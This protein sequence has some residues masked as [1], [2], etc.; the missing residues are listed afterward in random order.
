MT[1]FAVEYVYGTGTDAARDE[2]RP[3]HRAFLASLTDAEGVSLVASGP[4]ADGSGALLIL[5]A[6]DEARLASALQQ[7]PFNA[8]GLVSAL[9]TTAWIPATGELAHH[10]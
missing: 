8:Q 10:A 9:R 7:D 5:R 3:E 1:I 2:H 6:P 4:Y